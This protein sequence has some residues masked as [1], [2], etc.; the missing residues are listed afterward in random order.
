M[1]NDSRHFE[2]E[3]RHLTAEPPRRTFLG[4]AV[5]IGLMALAA[6]ILWAAAN[7]LGLVVHEW[8]H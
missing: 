1:P 4:A 2:L 7:W 8:P 3:P 6:V 5:V